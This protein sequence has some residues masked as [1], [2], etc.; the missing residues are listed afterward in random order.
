M[1]MNVSV[2]EELV[3]GL[4]TFEKHV[5]TGLPRPSRD[6]HYASDV[7]NLSLH[8]S[9]IILQEDILHASLDAQVTQDKGHDR[10]RNAL[11]VQLT[12]AR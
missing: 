4:C 3:N 9:P 12:L 1:L 2:I 6:M 10:E 5:G 11:R 7:V 8:A